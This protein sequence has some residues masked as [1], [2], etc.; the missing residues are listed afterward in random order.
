M[1]ISKDKKDSRK[2]EDKSHQGERNL[3]KKEDNLM[4][5]ISFG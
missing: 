4:K 1:W 3:H 2:K 5:N